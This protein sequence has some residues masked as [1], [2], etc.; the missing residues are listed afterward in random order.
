MSWFKYNPRAIEFDRQKVLRVVRDFHEQMYGPK[1]KRVMRKVERGP[2]V[3]GLNNALM[4]EFG[5]WVDGW[6]WATGEGGGGGPISNWCCP[7]HSV[8][9]KGDKSFDDTVERIGDAVEEWYKFLSTLDEKFEIING[10]CRDAHLASHIDHA[11]SELLPFVLKLTRANDAW[12]YTFM[13]MLN[14]YLE[15]FGIYGDKIEDELERIVEGG[16]SS[17]CEPTA[18]QAK[19][20]C[21]KLGQSVEQL[22][23]SEPAVHGYESIDAT[24]RWV[25]YRPHLHLDP[26]QMCR[27][28]VPTD[29]HMEFIE[30][31]DRKRS[32]VRADRMKEAL[33]M[34]RAAATLELPLTWELLCD[35]QSVVLGESA[36]FRKGDAFAKDGREC[37]P[38]NDGTQSHFINFLADANDDSVHAVGRA[39]RVYLDICFFHPFPDGNA[40]AARLAL[41]FVLTRANRAVLI[42]EPLFLLPQVPTNF[43][44]QYA[45]QT[46]AGR[47]NFS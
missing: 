21:H 30:K 42:A 11:A 5:P 26:N 23:Q 29:R 44:F 3:H 6:T 16:F 17:W 41:D 20:V 9:R 4:V 47:K 38:L 8:W 45:V 25:L 1:Y 12:Y 34:C 35:W 22:A 15:F 36:E 31:Y 33:E 40:R 14:W 13:T 18:E 27:L 7:E 43:S 2:F 37:Y 24:A 10:E 32:S 19:S 39:A 46:L 28:K